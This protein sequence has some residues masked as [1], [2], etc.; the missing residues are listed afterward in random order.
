MRLS[1]PFEMEFIPL[2][3]SLLSI[4]DTITTLTH[5]PITIPTHKH[6]YN[7][8]TYN[9]HLIKILSRYALGKSS[10]G[11]L[12]MKSSAFSFSSAQIC[13]MSALIAAS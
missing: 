10:E 5:N 9:K 1:F 11:W 13:D 4:S 2:E 6:T 7:K 3:S 12:R 8:H